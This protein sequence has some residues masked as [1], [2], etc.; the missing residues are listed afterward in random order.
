MSPDENEK[1]RDEITE[2]VLTGEDVE[3][4]EEHFLEDVTSVG[5]VDPSVIPEENDLTSGTSPNGDEDAVSFESSTEVFTDRVSI[6]AQP[7]RADVGVETPRDVLENRGEAVFSEVD[8]T[9]VPAPVEDTGVLRRSLVEPTQPMPVRPEPPAPVPLPDDETL[10]AGATVL[11]TVPGRAGGRW[12]SAIAFLLLTPVVWYLLSDAGARF[13]VAEANPW[14]TGIV[15]LAGI[16][17]FV[18]GLALI[19]LLGVVAA[20]SSL[21]LLLSGVLFT[22]AGLPFLVVPGYTR[23]FLESALDPSLNGLGAFGQNV[24]FHLA[25]TGATGI[26]TIIGVTLLTLSWVVYRV[27]RKGRSEENL[28]IEVSH[29]NPEGLHARWARKASQR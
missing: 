8:E 2:P 4:S 24:S 23:Q 29:T 13:F 1:Q 22:V 21:G 20:Q 6:S 19:V 15:N 28:R 3:L 16:A 7:D 17:E 5:D 12:L 9:M 14:Q 18:G 25:F 10:F 11:P 26:L 27:R